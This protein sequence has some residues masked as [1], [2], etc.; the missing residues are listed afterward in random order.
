MK[1]LPKFIW[2]I[3][4]LGVFSA[5]FASS[6]NDIPVKKGRK[7][8]LNQLLV[9]AGKGDKAAQMEL[10]N[11]YF[12][13]RGVPK[14]RRQAFKWYMA[15]AKQG[16]PL[17]QNYVGVMYEN[18]LGIDRN[19]E[20]ALIWLRRASAQGSP[21]GQFELAMLYSRGF[22]AEDER[23]QQLALL[24]KSASQYYAPANDRLGI[25]AYRG[26]Q[27]GVDYHRALRY[28]L[29]AAYGNDGV[30]D[31][32]LAKMYS[33]GDGVTQ[34]DII[35]YVFAKNAMEH[36]GNGNKA[37]ADRVDR[38]QKRIK[39]KLSPKDLAVAE[40]LVSDAKFNGYGLVNALSLRVYQATGKSL[41]GSA[42]PLRDPG[43]GPAVI[44]INEKGSISLF[45]RTIDLPTLKKKLEVFFDH[46]PRPEVQ[47][48][49][50]GILM[51][52]VENQ[53]FYAVIADI[54]NLKLSSL[55]LVTQLQG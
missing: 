8:D 44:D 25:Y 39:T 42:D 43:I 55:S 19:F 35:A 12:S 10:G 30:A 9:G 45:G 16:V 14:D 38:L 6:N 4:Y 53:T 22:G 20:D 33:E 52:P 5:A 18:G 24:S 21:E 54:K 2:L 41:L 37:V 36:L 31:Y 23:T 1:R 27:G 3:L 28:F 11:I 46:A 51:T 48:F 50:K 32:Y 15:C 34:D 47:V 13:G 40:E 7:L 29:M 49:I 26:S 17:A